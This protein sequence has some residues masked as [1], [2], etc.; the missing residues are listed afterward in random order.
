MTG[1]RLALAR[2][3]EG[4]SDKI[5]ELSRLQREDAKELRTSVHNL[6]KRVVKIE[7][8]TG[9]T[10]RDGRSSTRRLDDKT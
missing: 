4:L 9:Y 2:R 8:L 5:A 6:D 3:I 7:T 10:Q 1:L